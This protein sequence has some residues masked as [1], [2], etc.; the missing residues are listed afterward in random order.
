[1]LKSCLHWCPESLWITNEGI[2]FGPL[3]SIPSTLRSPSICLVCCA[4]KLVGGSGGF[5]SFSSFSQ[6]GKRF[7]RTNFSETDSPYNYCWSPSRPTAQP[8][9]YLNWKQRQQGCSR[10]G[11]ALCSACGSSNPDEIHYIHF[12]HKFD[13]LSLTKIQIAPFSVWFAWSG[14]DVCRMSKI[15]FYRPLNSFPRGWFE[16]FLS[17]LHCV[18][19]AVALDLPRRGYHDVWLLLDGHWVSSGMSSGFRKSREWLQGGEAATSI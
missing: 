14:K 13:F 10:L 15:L 19:P 5:V 9:C 4:E 3:R 1:M 6:L 2:D 18:H 17:L 11:K 8:R 7:H 12:P 16:M